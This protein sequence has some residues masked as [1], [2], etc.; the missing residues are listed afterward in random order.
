MDTDAD[1]LFQS[2]TVQPRKEERKEGWKEGVA[3]IDPSKT[4][5]LL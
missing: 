2:V 4:V 3:D 5:I 1:R